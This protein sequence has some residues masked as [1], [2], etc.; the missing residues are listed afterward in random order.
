MK[1]AANAPKP[2]I[3]QFSPEEFSIWAANAPPAPTL[4]FTGADQLE[5]RDTII[6][7]DDRYYQSSSSYPYSAIGRMYISSSD[8]GFLCSGTLVGPRLMASARHC[9]HDGASYQFSPGYK[10]GNVYPTAVATR[11]VSLA[12]DNTPGVCDNKNDWALYVLDKPIGLDRGYLGVGNYEADEAAVSGQPIFYS[13]GYPGDRDN[14]ELLYMSD[15]R[16]TSLGERNRCSNVGCILGDADTAGGMS[17]GP[18]WRKLN[19]QR[20]LYGTLFGGTA[21]Y[22]AW[23]YGPS[24]IKAVQNLNAQYPN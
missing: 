8:G 5:K 20:F 21:D 12:H 4:N 1:A 18:L 23:A 17:G 24:F 13:A 15:S 11:I 10:K 6:G 7:K 9:I 2:E 16:T 3:I 19:D 22:S 14:A